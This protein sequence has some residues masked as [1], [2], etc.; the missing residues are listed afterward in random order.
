MKYGKLVNNT[1]VYA[2]A[3]YD[4]RLPNVWLINGNT[5]SEILV[6]QGFKPVHIL[7]NK[8]DNSLDYIETIEET[9]NSIN[10]LYTVNNTPCYLNSLREEKIAQTRDNLANFLACNP[11][12]SAVKDGIQR[13][14][15]V[16]KE[17]QANLSA[18]IS[19]YGNVLLQYIAKGESVPTDLPKLY[20]NCAGQLQEEWT[21]EQLMQLK[22]E[23]DEYVRPYVSM[24]QHLEVVIYGLPTQQEIKN[25]NIDYTH[26]NIQFWLINIAKK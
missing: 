1:L 16:T 17:K 12:N 3:F 15:T 24:Q 10:I 11:L 4:D 2:D 8:I 5:S 14:Y 9:D 22:R 23:I 18:L 6:Q 7:Q 25:L 21:Y 19:Y 13:K 26:E 20:W